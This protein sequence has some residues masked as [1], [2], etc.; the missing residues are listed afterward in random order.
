M[1]N[2]NQYTNNIDKLF[3]TNPYSLNNQ[4]KKKIFL[5]FFNFL[6]SHHYK[7]NKNYKKI[8]QDIYSN[9]LHFKNI[10]KMPFITSSLFKDVDLKSIKKKNIIKQLNSSGTTGNTLAKIYLDKL[11][12]SNQVKTLQNIVESEIGQKRLPMLII[13]CNPKEKI[14]NFSKINARIAAINGFSIFGKNHTFALNQ[15]MTVNYASVNLFLKKFKDKPF[16]VFGF[17]SLI[18]LYFIKKL[19]NNGQ[20]Y[21]FSN[22]I[23]IHGGGWKKLEKLNISNKKFCYLL[24]KKIGA[25]NI[26]NYYGLVE[27]T[28][29]IF[30][31]CNKCRNF[32]TSNFSEVV[33]RDKDFNAQ[34][35]NKKGLIQ[36]FSIIPTSYAGHILLT[37][38][39]GE[40]RS[41]RKCKKCQKKNGT[42]FR[43]YGRTQM[44]EVRGCSDTI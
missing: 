43:I 23:I 26:I 42:R 29:S 14:K 22:S 39:E 41:H 2:L 11:N 20:K 35:K 25:Q 10:E 5:K 9:K 40:I 21:D 32:I 24:K 15:N 34:K 37:E 16:L 4:K 13:D 27:Q 44:A 7:K 19:N 1:K 6:I 31:E 30:F 12:A 28:G 38:D 33:I 18:Y 17:T 3:K 8:I 36:L